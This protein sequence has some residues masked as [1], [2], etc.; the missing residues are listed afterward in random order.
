MGRYFLTTE[1]NGYLR[2]LK[3]LYSDN[4]NCY[5][6][7]NISFDCPTDTQINRLRACD[8]RDEVIEAI[9]QASQSFNSRMGNNLTLITPSDFKYYKVP[10][11]EQ[12]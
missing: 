7:D 10:Y 1:T 9:C 4:N 6:D 5:W 11:D 3:V 8:W 2:T 12:H